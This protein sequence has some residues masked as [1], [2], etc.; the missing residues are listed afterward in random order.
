MDLLLDIGQGTVQGTLAG[1]TIDF[2]D[3]DALYRFELEA[4]I[5][6][7]REKD[8][9]LILSSYRDS[10]SSLSFTLSAVEALETGQVMSI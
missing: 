4:F 2:G 7:I 5:A 9:S 10:L 8:Q 3:S 6:A 1:E